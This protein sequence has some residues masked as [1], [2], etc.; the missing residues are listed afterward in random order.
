MNKLKM[1]LL[2]CFMSF[3]N[4]FASE[5]SYPVVVIGGGVGGL[6]SGL[7][8]ARA[9]IKPL[10][11]EGKTPSQITQAFEVENWP[12]EE[13]IPGIKLIEKM[14]KQALSNG[15]SIAAKEVVEVDFTKNPKKIVLKDP[16]SSENET[17][18]TQACIIATGSTPNKLNIAGEEKYSGSGVSYCALC[19][20][21]FY[22][23]KVV[24]VVGGGDS[25]LIEAN[26]LSNLAKKVFVIV[27]KSDF[28]PSVDKK[29]KELVLKQPNVEVMYNSSP[30]AISG[31]GQIVTYLEVRTTDKGS[32]QL[33]KIAV[34]GV[35][36]AIGS[37]PNTSLFKEELNLD[38]SGLIVINDRH[39]TSRE[40]VFAIGDVIRA[41]N[42][43]AILAAADGA[44]GAIEAQK[45][46]QD[47]RMIRKETALKKQM[48][49][50]DMIIEIES[51]EQFE[52]EIKESKTPVL[53]DFYATW[54]GPCKM[55]APY[56]EKSAKELSHV[57]KFLKVNV[58]KNKNIAS[59]M[60]IRAMPTIILF[61]AD[62]MMKLKRV[63]PGQISDL[64][65]DIEKIKNQPSDLQ[66]YIIN[67]K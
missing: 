3:V 12:G 46:L 32:K 5:N 50:K 17:I 37:T 67:Q 34:D 41:E 53:V 9:G 13:K 30:E 59:K 16:F 28:K 45:Y 61:D 15:C 1:F 66:A 55:I 23:D 19:D 52:K 6:T 4:L 38:H 10:I 44:T 22:R 51:L 26:Y 43:Q 31:D 29:N 64:I 35:F 63:G 60:G 21:S 54:C 20:G 25:A 14:K 39:Q 33:K 11:V 62:G 2:I 7:Y 65:S 40:G 27:R 18:Y 56:L 42:K 57:V 48:E 24:A 8:L 36:V 58:D 49:K 47:K